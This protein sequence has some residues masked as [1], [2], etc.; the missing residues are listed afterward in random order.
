MKRLLA[1]AAG[2]LGGAIPAAAQSVSPSPS[3]AATVT[4]TATAVEEP[5][6]GVPV[7]VDVLDAAAI[8]Q[9]QTLETVDLLRTIPGLE[10]VRTGS[11]GKAASLFARGT[12]SSHTLVL[13]NGVALNDPYLGGFDFSTLS[14]DGALR[15]EVVRGPYSA[16][17]G[18]SAVGGVV[19]VVTG[20]GGAAGGRVRLEAG[21]DELL[22]AQAAG[23]FDVGRL[24]VDATGHLRQ[25]EGAV[26]NDSYD[27]D[28]LALA[29]D[30]ELG[31]GAR[32]GA[33][34]RRVSA[35]I[36]IP[37]GYDGAPTPARRQLS[38]ATTLGLPFDWSAGAWSVEAS[39]ATTATDLTVE[40]PADPWAASDA[41]ARREQAR[42]TVRREL[43]GG[44]SLAAGGDWQRD[45]VESSSAFGPALDG[46]TQRTGAAFLQGS[47]ARGRF[48][49]DAGLRRDESDVFGGATSLRA[50][51]AVRLGDGLRLRGGYGESF[52]APSLADLYYPGF[53]NPDL[54]PERGASYELALDGERGALRFTVAA[55]ENRLDELIEFDYAT[56]TPQNL[57]RARARGVEASLGVR[58][59]AL[60]ARLAVTR[61]D[62]ED[63]D[64]GR[65]LLRR[66]DWSS[67]FTAFATR[68]DW[69]FGLVGRYVGDRVDFGEI[70]LDPYA[71][72]DLSLAWRAAGWLEPFVRV[73]NLA[74]AAYEEAAGFPAPGR[75]VAAGCALRF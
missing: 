2:L 25:G 63:L 65:P 71:T 16:L 4:V 14:T 10:I 47:F 38:D 31:S 5:A 69:T 23:R 55:F 6:D 72:L 45:E 50:A 9:R 3:F 1:L 37:Y 75:G 56:F 24:G 40:D 49:L 20:R 35:E 27:G 54:R 7:A 22:S 12:N 17:Y 36:G 48:R 52:R 46:E 11:P 68:G 59:A 21:S 57:G 39:A 58:T 8:E 51:A 44:L 70:A 18:S 64:T 43:A 34:V 28:E 60:D 32:L 13:W 42:L 66:P 61:L 67:S 41:D 26:D 74:D 62:A 73:A 15:L 30:Y 19:Q 29:L 33:L 53:S